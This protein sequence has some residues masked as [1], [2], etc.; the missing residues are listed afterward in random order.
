MNRFA[1]S[2]PKNLPDSNKYHETIKIEVLNN[3]S[4]EGELSIDRYPVLELDQASM[5]YKCLQQQ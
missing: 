1:K 2:S 5:P 4:R 3:C